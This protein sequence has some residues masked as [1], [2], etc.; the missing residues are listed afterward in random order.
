MTATRVL[1]VT[2]MLVG[3]AMPLS[4]L[5]LCSGGAVV[6][7]AS[8][9]SRPC[10]AGTP[11]LSPPTQK[12][13]DS[14]Q[15][16]ISSIQQAAPSP[17][18]VV[19]PALCSQ[20]CCAASGPETRKCTADS[21]SKPETGA[22]PARLAAAILGVVVFLAAL[23]ALAATVVLARALRL[24]RT[25]GQRFSTPAAG[26]VTEE[27]FA[28]TNLW[29]GFG[30][31]R[32]GLTIS[33]RLAELIV[34]LALAALSTWIAATVAGLPLLRETESMDSSTTGTK[35]K[36]IGAG[37]AADGAAASAAS[38]SDQTR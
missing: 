19:A 30:G 23:L 28:V 11:K 32:T 6:S 29:G 18:V 14:V 38:A 25:T 35:D 17:P 26:E 13:A 7:P 15:I 5:A 27:G 22:V 12:G 10:G 34:G 9:A 33:P 21:T 1:S 4:A 2:A 37:A 20:A 3:S 8:A 36:S 31:G 16:S 24:I